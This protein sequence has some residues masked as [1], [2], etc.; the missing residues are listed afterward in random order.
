MSNEQLNTGTPP[1]GPEEN[2]EANPAAKK[3][4]QPKPWKKR[5]LKVCAWIAGIFVG[6]VLL[7]MCLIAWILTPERLTPLVEKY[8]SEFLL[9]DVKAGRVELTV[10]SSFPDIRLDVQDLRLTSRT[11]QGQPDSVLN[12]LPKDAANLLQAKN[13]NASI[14]PWA[15]LTGTISLGDINAD[16][17][18]VNLV[19]YNTEVNNYMIVPPSEEKE[20]EKDVEPWDI[21][22]GRVT[23]DAP[24]GIRYFDASMGVDA[25]LGTT[26]LTVNPKNDDCTLLSTDFTSLLSLSMGGERYVSSL[27]LSL[28]GDVRMQW[29]P[30]SFELP[31]YEAILGFI[32]TKFSAALD[33]NDEPILKQFNIAVTPVKVSEVLKF[34]PQELKDS[35]PMLTAISTDMALGLD[36]A[37]QSPWVFSKAMPDFKANFAVAPCSLSLTDPQTHK[38]LTLDNIQ[39]KG[40]LLYTGAAPENSRLNIPLLE[41]QGEGVALSL[42]A[43]AERLLSDN[44]LV[45][46]TSK[47]SVDLERI[48]VLLPLQGATLKGQINADASVKGSLEDFTALRYENIDANGSMQVRGLLFSLPELATE[49]YSNLIDFAFGN[50]IPADASGQ[51]ITGAL[52]FR[53]DI[54]TLHC[55]VPGIEVGLGRGV[56]RGGTSNALLAGKTEGQITPMG[57]LLSVDR[58]RMD[59]PG[60]TMKVYARGLRADGFITRYEGNKESPLLRSDLSA[61]GLYYSD[62][63]MRVGLKEFDANLTAHLRPRDAKANA[64]T[65]YQ[66]RYDRLAK[67]YPGLSRDSIAALASR[68]L[69]SAYENQEVIRLEMDNGVKDLFR[70]WGISGSLKSDKIALT[71]IMYPA[72][73]RL[74]GLDMEFSLDSVRLHRVHLHTQDNALSLWGTIS[75][76]RQMMLGRTRRPIKVRLYADI[77]SLDINQVAYNFTLGSALQSQRGYLARLSPEEQNALVEAAAAIDTVTTSAS[78]SVSLLIPRNLDVNIGLTADKAR[79]TDIN[80][81]DLRTNLILNDGAASVDS[82]S[83]ATDFGDAYLNLLYSSRN[84]ELL[85]LAV[86]LGFS[87]IDIT[88]FLTTFPT[89][90]EM[91]PTV[92]NLSGMVGAKLVGSFDMY[93]NMDIDFN[94]MNAMLNIY[95]NGLRLEQDPMIRKIARMMLIRKKGALELSDID[96]QVS[97]HD[98]V[99]RLYPFKFGME[100]YRFAL[101][102]ENDLSENMYYHLSVLKSPIPFKFGI[103]IKGTFEKPKIR[104]GGAKYHENEAMQITN[105]IEGERVNFVHAMR[106]ELRKLVN[107]ATLNYA[108][109]ANFSSYGLDKEL[110]KAGGKD[111]ER[112]DSQFESPMQMVGSQ[113]GGSVSKALGKSSGLQE[114]YRKMQEKNAAKDK[115]KK[116]K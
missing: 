77:D 15:L 114:V 47:G 43:L 113:L 87:N 61:G 71:H 17:V 1:T 14:N 100:K 49:I 48:G 70:Q 24:G 94:S 5:V 106:L 22:F 41:L 27:P 40:D 7:A 59:A 38:S 89:V 112:D 65:P 75:N 8:G 10:W 69:A 12:A 76:I 115:K 13:I 109:R 82:L 57:I 21:R 42:T 104:F 67:Q 20:V 46:L 54:D 36:A 50:N 4:K 26:K 16:G 33:L 25:L 39:L 108:E 93:P 110:K 111:D 64:K 30:M 103:N 68:P 86:D 102:G 2:K 72:P 23:L 81:Y 116:K 11:L 34:L 73:M 45:T 90:V 99:V 53:A 58:F 52:R 28:A 88:N 97:L 6:L 31:G 29:H 101:L 107:K 80:L 32:A 35:V 98:N 85:N 105:L 56:V 9:A 55:A 44:P 3:V 66:R 91:A 19:A 74:S 96:I 83:A 60:D 92:S 51:Q 18:G 78:D 95:G 37:M 62:P 79:Y 84:P 63:T